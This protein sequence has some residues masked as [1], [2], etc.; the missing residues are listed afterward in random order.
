MTLSSKSVRTRIHSGQSLSNLS[1]S[2]PLTHTHAHT[3][4]H[5]HTHT[6]TYT[7]IVTHTYN[8]HTYTHL[9]IHTYTHAHCVCMCACVV[10]ST[11]AP[12][13]GCIKRPDVKQIHS[14]RS[15]SFPFLITSTHRKFYA[16]LNLF[17]GSSAHLKNVNWTFAKS[18]E[19]FAYKHF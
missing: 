10:H 4:T 1:L 11:H 3:L 9:H 19:V 18:N 7:H 14:T 8:V 15:K 13:L 12:T 5:P 17:R 16:I 6:R 2:L